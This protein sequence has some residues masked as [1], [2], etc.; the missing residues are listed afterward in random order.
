MP[1]K[2]PA[3]RR[4]KAARYSLAHYYRQKSKKGTTACTQCFGV[5]D[6]GRFKKCTK[7]REYMRH[8]K[9]GYRA[10]PK[11][12]GVCTVSD[13]VRSVVG[14][15]KLCATCRKK[16]RARQQ[17]PRTQ[18]ARQQWRYD[19]RPEVIAAYGG[20]C[21]CC[22]ETQLE[23]LS[24]D[25][26]EGYAD[27]PRAG[28]DLYSSLKRR[29]YPEGFRVLCMTCNFTLGHHG[30]CPHG[31]L[32]QVLHTGRPRVRPETEQSRAKARKQYEYCH[33]L[34]R[35]ALGAYGGTS[36]VCCGEAHIECLGIDHAA[37]DGAAHRR[38]DGGARNLYIWLRK[39]GY[40]PGFRV[41][42]HG[43]NHAAGRFGGVCPHKHVRSSSTPALAVTMPQEL[44]T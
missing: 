15:F 23:F 5:R 4:E 10:A 13:C 44:R 32:T 31:A 42:C 14:D 7:C 29:G 1:Y 2:D 19:L 27:G 37:N 24:I 25:H 35:A 3:V 30:Y 18:K 26:I 43:C 22:A 38:T 41:L 16:G 40:P 12:P 20:R 8:Y 21:L 11:A 28:T 6:D 34:K 36:C 39:N 33:A 9:A 17:L